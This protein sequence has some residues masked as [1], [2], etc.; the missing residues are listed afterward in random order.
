MLTNR[1]S[2]ALNFAIKTHDG[3]P[4]KGM[5]DVPYVSHLLIVAGLALEYGADEEVTVAALLHDAAEDGGGEATLAEIRAHFGDRVADIV[6]GCSDTYE[7]PKPDWRP[8]KEAYIKRIASEPVETRLVSAADKLHN[9]SSSIR[10]YRVRGDAFFE[11]FSGGKDGTLWYYR[12]LV[13]AFKQAGG[14]DA[15]VQDLDA[16]VSEFERLCRGQS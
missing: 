13:D 14:N 5:A 3:Q 6:A 7:K 16:A 11:P 2:E 10:D 1:L 9:V 12:S 8:R 15:L 4:R